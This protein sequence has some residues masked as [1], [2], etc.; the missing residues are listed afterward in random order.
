MKPAPK[1]RPR[2]I[3]VVVRFVPASPTETATIVRLLADLMA[4]G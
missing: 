2:P 1:P 4:K 3:K